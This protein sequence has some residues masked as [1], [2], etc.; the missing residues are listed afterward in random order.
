MKGSLNTKGSRTKHGEPLL[1]CQSGD[2]LTI[3]GNSK[4]PQIETS[5]FAILDLGFKQVWPTWESGLSNSKDLE[6][7]PQISRSMEEELPMSSE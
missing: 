2:A 6:Y 1:Y 7:T 4:Q 3:E 5:F